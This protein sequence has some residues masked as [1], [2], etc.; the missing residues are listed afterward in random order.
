MIESFLPNLDIAGNGFGVHCH[1][2]S[3]PWY[4][5]QISLFEQLTAHEIRQLESRSLFCKV[6]KNRN[7]FLPVGHEDDVVIV[8]KGKANLQIPDQNQD[9]STG[10]LIVKGDML[11]GI[12]SQT[13]N[14]V[15]SPLT[16]CSSCEFVLIPKA[17]LLDLIG[18]ERDRGILQASVVGWRRRLSIPWNRILFRPAQERLSAVLTEVVCNQTRSLGKTIS[19]PLRDVTF[20]TGLSSSSIRSAIEHIGVAEIVKIGHRTLSCRSPRSLQKILC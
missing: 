11:G 6:G 8:S 18:K 17:E 20:L 19:I 9:A 15:R 7:A 5:K 3:M 12:P 1:M 2:K 14:E 10:V 16:T 4:F 13:R